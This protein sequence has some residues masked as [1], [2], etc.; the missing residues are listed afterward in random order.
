M[1]WRNRQHRVVSS[2]TWSHNARNPSLARNAGDALPS[3]F[4]GAQRRC[5][6][7]EQLEQYERIA[8]NY[9]V[10]LCNRT[11][12][13][14]VSVSVCPYVCTSA[15]MYA[16]MHA[17]MHDVCMNVCMYVRMYVRVYVCVYVCHVCMYVYMYLCMYLYDL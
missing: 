16:C 17:C 15:Y 13:L 14:H 12:C 4:A 6:A 3:G 7:W 2:E 11:E 9:E 8:R 1:T 10:M 5:D